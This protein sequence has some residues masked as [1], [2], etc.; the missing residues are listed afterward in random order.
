[1]SNTPSKKLNRRFF[2]RVSALAGG[3]ILLGGGIEASAQQRGGTPRNASPI[4]PS[5]FIQIDP[6]GM[7]TLTAKNPEM[8]QGIKTALPMIIADELDLDWKLVR[9][10][11]ADLNEVKYG[12]QSAGGSR[13]TPNNWDLLRRIGASARSMM[14]D[15]AAQTWSVPAAECYTELGKVYQFTITFF[16]PK[17]RRMTLKPVV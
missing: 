2:L 13:S 9:V 16:E 14:I 12:S 4:L 3:S 17:E 6:N 7:V 5:A 1:M 15:A 11:Q 10:V 8:G